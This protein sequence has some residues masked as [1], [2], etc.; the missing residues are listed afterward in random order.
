MKG[1][2]NSCPKCSEAEPRQLC[3]PPADADERDRDQGR[4]QHHEDPCLDGLER[5]AAAGRLIGGEPAPAV[6][7]Q[8]DAQLKLRLAG[9]DRRFGWE[10]RANG[11]TT[12]VTVPAAT[13]RA[14]AMIAPVQA[15]ALSGYR[16]RTAT[17][18]TVLGSGVTIP[19][20]HRPRA[21]NQGQR[22]AASHATSVILAGRCPP[23]H[24]RR[25]T[26]QWSGPLVLAKRA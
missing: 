20:R 9:S 23:A 15:S 18:L 4:G 7:S 25:R 3:V 12:A 21:R 17:A 11:R 13:R 6:R 26:A 1:P 16:D 8:A 22:I 2:G 19:V 24:E 5:P 14:A 10:L